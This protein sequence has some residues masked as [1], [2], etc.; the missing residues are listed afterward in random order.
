MSFCSFSGRSQNDG[1]G[2]ATFT[3]FSRLMRALW[4]RA[5]CLTIASPDRLPWWPAPPIHPVEAPNTLDCASSDT[6]A[7]IADGQGA[8]M[9]VPGAGGDELD[10]AAG[11]IVADGVVAQ[12][13]AQL[14]QLIPVAKHSGTLTQIG[15]GDERCAFSFLTFHTI[16]GHVQQIDRFHVGLC[17]GLAA[18]VQMRQL[19][20]VVHQLDHPAGFYTFDL[21]AK[22]GNIGGFGI[23]RFNE[24]RIAGKYWS[25][26][27]SARG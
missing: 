25:E 12:V 7:V 14:I 11:S 15:Q 6:D 1:D 23:R 24:F 20:D 13:L 8:I 26:E 17:M 16:L 4:M 2:G 5:M 9:A 27:F 19:Q 3:T 10:L 21:P 18:A 22:L